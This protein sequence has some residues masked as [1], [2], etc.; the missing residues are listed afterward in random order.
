MMAGFSKLDLPVSPP[1]PPMEAKRLEKI[2]EGE[3]LFEPKWDGFRALV[4]RDGDEVAIQSKS[5]KPLD[6]YFPELVETFLSVPDERF[7][8]D[9]EIVIESGE[10]ISFDEL[11]LRIHPAE[12]RI[13]KLAVEI[14]ASFIAFDLLVDRGRDLSGESLKARRSELEALHR[15]WD[16]PFLLS[17]S[18]SD[19]ATAEHWF[20][21]LA[22][23]GLDG[24][25]AKYPDKAYQSGNRE[26]MFKVKHFRT[27]DCVLGGYRLKDDG[28]LGSLLLGLY[29][30]D[31]LVYIG[32]TAPLPSRI[33]DE[34]Q[35]L[36]DTVQGDSGFLHPPGGESRWTGNKPKDWVA[37]KPVL[38]AE[39]RYDHFSEGRFRHGSKFLR[40]R[41]DKSPRDC[42]IE[43]VTAPL[44]GRLLKKL[45]G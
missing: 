32:H 1:F 12:S 37:L 26:G 24:V 31:E 6:R 8:L 23:E 13:R 45:T 17:P 3:F 42:H 5:Q 36:L 35:E 28:S 15:R 39:V 7:V 27:V 25:M 33:R 21:E 29:D 19:R 9:G 34:T 14:P 16:R 43:Q 11:L 2:P 30:D 44:R 20:A 4:F 10:T 22:S 38:V 40:W 41:P 18:T